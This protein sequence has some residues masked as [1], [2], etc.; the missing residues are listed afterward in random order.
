MVDLL[1]YQARRNEIMQEKFYKC[2]CGKEFTKP[3]SFNGH[4]SHCKIHLQHTGNWDKIQTQNILRYTKV[5]ETL[6]QY[7]KINKDIKISQWLSENHTCEKCGKVMTEKFGSGRF[8]SRTCANSRNMSNETKN[9]IK[10]SFSKLIRPKKLV[11]ALKCVVC[12]SLFY[13]SNFRKTCSDECFH[14]L[15]S[16]TSKNNVIKN[17]GNLNPNPNKNCKTGTY[18]G[19]HYDSSWELAFIIYNL[20][21]GINIERNRHGF[22]YIYDNKTHLYYPDFIINNEY[23][24]I[25]NYKSDIVVAKINQFPKNLILH[26]L[27]KN[28]I[29]PYLDYCINKYGND[30]WNTV[31]K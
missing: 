13:T 31:D 20:E 24:E 2:E 29:K 25:K 1:S 16:I 11:Q 27:Y 9:K 19:F 28:D 8:C 17:G 10:K 21:N 30:F 18:K 4:K 23:Y 12:E 7:N 6:K 22:A 15:L 14:K 3:N 5:S 26:V